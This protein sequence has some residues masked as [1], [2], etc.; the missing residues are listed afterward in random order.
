M[1]EKITQVVYRSNDFEY[2]KFTIPIE[3]FR[4]LALSGFQCNAKKISLSE[5]GFASGKL[6]IWSL[7]EAIQPVIIAK[8]W[9]E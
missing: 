7:M 6:L 1:V 8:L 5:N 9:F 4:V 3:L 2:V